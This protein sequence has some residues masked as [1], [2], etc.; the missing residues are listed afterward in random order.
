MRSRGLPEDFAGPIRIVGIEGIEDDMCCGTHVSNLSQLQVQFN[1]C[2]L[3]HCVRVC[4]HVKYR[5]HIEF[6][7]IKLVGTE[8]GKKNKTNLFFLAGNRV[9]KYAEKSYNK[10]R[11]LVSLLK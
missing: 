6:Q 3:T 7:V 10:D 11:S 5:V 2:I 1:I 9:I 4:L 8:K